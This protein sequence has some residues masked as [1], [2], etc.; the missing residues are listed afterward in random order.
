MVDSTG[1]ITAI[2]HDREGRLIIEIN[3]AGHYV[4]DEVRA[5]ISK[6]PVKK[7]DTVTYR[8][9]DRHIAFLKAGQA[10]PASRIKEAET[11]PV[12]P[13]GPAPEPEPSP[14]PD[15][16][17]AQDQPVPGVERTIGSGETFGLDPSTRVKV[18]LSVRI[19]QYE[20]LRVGVDGLAS[21]RHDLIKL[22]T[23]L[24]NGFGKDEVTRDMI[25]KYAARVLPAN[26]MEPTTSPAA[27]IVA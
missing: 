22:L 23:N 10:V 16:T 26:E 9:K 7:G 5:F 1:V 18:E 25:A 17:P 24:L 27:V 8:I 2:G 12:T 13:P 3:Q 19:G 4:T 14:P 15:K 6:H 20:T 21:E 11:P